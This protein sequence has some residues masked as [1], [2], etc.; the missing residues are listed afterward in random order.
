MTNIKR[1]LYQRLYFQVLLGIAFGVT[2]G[3]FYPDI[4]QTMKPLGDA[5]IRLIRMMVAPIIFCTITVGIAK[6]GDMR[7]VGRVGAK[8]LL[9]FEVVSTLA[10]VIGLITVNLLEPGTGVNADPNAL[11]TK[12]ISNY[13]TLASHPLTTVEFLMNIIPETVVDAFT[14][15]GS[16]LQVLLFSVFFGISL[17]QF[18]DKGRALIKLLDQTSHSLFG[19]IGIIMKFAPFGAFGAMSFSIGKFG[20]S[21]LLPLGKLMIGVYATC[22]FFILFVLGPILRTAGFSIWKF[23]KYIKE[24]ILIVMGTNSSEVV[25]PRMI[26]KLENMGCAKPVVGLVI[27]TGYS[28]NLDGTSIYLTMA[29]VFLAQAMNIELSI[30][31]QITLLGVMM[32]TSKGAA[33]VPGGGFVTLASTLAATKDIPIEGLALL[34]GVDIF[35]S[36]IRSVTNL[37]GNGV[38]TIMV[39]KWEHALDYQKAHR[40]LDGETVL[41]ADDPEEVSNEEMEDDDADRNKEIIEVIEN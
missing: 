17:S 15:K 32:L 39:S 30:Y 26:T 2:L 13:T 35:M 6:M 24:E 19:V 16:T 1:P 38:A 34:L 41:D 37:I 36:E 31:Q 5:F 18:G 21:S 14:S 22:I 9:Y 27:P 25:L 33:A 3:H 4:G 29:A 40:V 20:L 28:F 23:I 11:D 8:S 10:L 12:S 7:E